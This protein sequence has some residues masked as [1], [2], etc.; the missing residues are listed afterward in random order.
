MFK[1]MKKYFENNLEAIAR[2]LAAISCNDI[3][4]YID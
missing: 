4:T 3:R 1:M 2:G